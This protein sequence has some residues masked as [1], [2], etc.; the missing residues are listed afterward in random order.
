[1]V[2]FKAT[3]LLVTM[4]FQKVLKV[5]PTNHLISPTLAPLY[6]L[7][8]SFETGLTELIHKHA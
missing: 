2:P 4:G 7:P 3:L 6:A 5:S 1:M 8:S